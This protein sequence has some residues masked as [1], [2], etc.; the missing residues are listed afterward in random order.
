M[1]DESP[2]VTTEPVLARTDI[3]SLPQ[4]ESTVMLSDLQNSLTPLLARAR[5]DEDWEKLD[6][7]ERELK[8][9]VS[10]DLYNLLQSESSSDTKD[11]KDYKDMPHLE[12]REDQAKYESAWETLKNNYYEGKFSQG[13]FEDGVDNLYNNFWKGK[14]IVENNPAN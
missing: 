8:S 11:Y 12:D 9:R 10:L 4:K 1:F 6:F 7:L 5:A 3:T 14:N 13:E 2:A